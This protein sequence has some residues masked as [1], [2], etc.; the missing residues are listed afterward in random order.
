L[1]DLTVASDADRAADPGARAAWAHAHR[2]APP[3]PGEAMTLTRF[4]I[5]RDTYQGPSPTLNAV[6]VLTLQR[7]LDTPNLAWD[8]L[9]LFEP[10]PWDDY[11][12]MADLP[13]AH[14]ADFTVDDRRY[15]LFAHDFRQT[16]VDEL[17][18]LWTERA[19]AQEPTLRP[20][21]APAVLVLS[22]P[23]F[24][25]AVRQALRDLHRQDL[26]ARNPLL[27]TR[28]V[29]AHTGHDEPDAAA[30]RELIDAA[31]GTLEQH[32]RDDKRL[33]AIDRTYLR[34]AGTQESAAALLG[35]PFSTYR[36]HLTQGVDRIVQWLW[37]RE[38]YGAVD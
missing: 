19:L 31:V 25:D 29:R 3:R 32:P 30:L 4:T 16:G 15:G 21:G 12:A 7:Y 20:A 37:D 34:P 1:L 26:L 10:E 5:D 6:P 17:I 36:R 2:Q 28:L 35:L 18:T 8:Y 22:H 24:A 23:D 9:A 33:R 11:F 27:R 38:L 13:R 14:G